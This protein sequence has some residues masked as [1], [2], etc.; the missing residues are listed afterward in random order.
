MPLN[1]GY[2]IYEDNFVY[3]KPTKG[4]DISK[5]KVP[6]CRGIVIESGYE[7]VNNI[8]ELNRFKCHIEPAK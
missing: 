4:M 2:Q 8:D 1:G 3:V 5:L 7:P 6:K